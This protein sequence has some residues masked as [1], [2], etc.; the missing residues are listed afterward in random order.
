M[1]MPIVGS[2]ERCA[3]AE[4]CGLRKVKLVFLYGNI[5]IFD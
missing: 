2:H 1:E 4:P 3:I 5:K